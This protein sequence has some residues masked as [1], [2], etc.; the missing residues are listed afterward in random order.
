MW[1]FLIVLYVTMYSLVKFCAII[2][3]RFIS[4]EG[5]LTASTAR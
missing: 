1:L 5:V 2:F 4:G 3:L